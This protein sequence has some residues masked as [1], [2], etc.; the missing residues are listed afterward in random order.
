VRVVSVCVVL[1]ESQKK[2]F[3]QISSKLFY[4]FFIIYFNLQISITS[5]ESYLPK[6]KLASY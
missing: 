3:S 1:R 2:M 5:M 4:R 6:I